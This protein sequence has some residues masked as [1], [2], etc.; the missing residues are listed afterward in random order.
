M[1]TGLGNLSDT[2]TQHTQSLCQELPVVPKARCCDVCGVEMMLSHVDLHSPCH[3]EGTPGL[4]L[5]P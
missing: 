5:G 1:R 3:W 4:S 2:W